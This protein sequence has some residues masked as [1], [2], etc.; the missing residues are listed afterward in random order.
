MRAHSTTEQGSA[1]H[2]IEA[3]GDAVMLLVTRALTE[4]LRRQAE[5]EGIG[6]GELLD[7]MVRQYLEKNG[8]ET[9]IGYLR[10]VGR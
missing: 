5:S 7:K 8:S 10:V 1:E 4:T 2:L 3:S 9:A 6:I